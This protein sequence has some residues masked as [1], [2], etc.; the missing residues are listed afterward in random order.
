M[1]QLAHAASSKNI[2]KEMKMTVEDRKRS[3]RLRKRVLKELKK[4]T[5]T[6]KPVKTKVKSKK[7]LKKDA[8][9][10]AAIL[11]AKV[12]KD[13]A[14]V[15]AIREKI[16]KKID[17][18]DY[19]IVFDRENLSIEKIKQIYKEIP[20][21][22]KAD[23]ELDRRLAKEAKKLAAERARAEKK[24][25][26]EVAKAADLI[27][28]AEA[29]KAKKLAAEQARAEKKALKEAADLRPKTRTQIKAEISKKLM[30][31]FT[32]WCCK[33]EIELSDGLNMLSDRVE[34][35]ISTM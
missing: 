35:V 28:K 19:G 34:V 29:K 20:M 26:K 23:K 9:K 31:N 12:L 7:A 21:L 5:P 3:K 25:L 24:A 33:N 1:E 27:F 22:R 18:T 6:V 10:K 17:D 15:T 14:K 16:L 4:T 32:R 30:K 2:L 8:E 13:A 11:A